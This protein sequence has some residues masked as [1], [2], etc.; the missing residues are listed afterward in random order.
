VK[1][2]AS[3]YRLQLSADFRLADA[4]AA[5]PYLD[6]LGIAALYLSP[7]T[8]ATPGSRHGYDCCD[9]TR[10][11]PELG[12]E[13]ELVLLS[14]A[15][16]ERGMGLLIDIVPNHMAASTHNPW[17]REVLAIGPAA[18]AADLFDIEWRRLGAGG[19]PQVLLPVLADR[20]GE[21]LARGDIR[22]DGDEVAYF[23]RRYP[24]AA[25][26]LDGLEAAKGD[27][28]GL[29]RLLER[30]HYRLADWRV[31]NERV[32]YRRFFDVS[33][34]VALRSQDPS[35]FERTHALALRLARAG[36][37]TGLR[38]DHV[39]GLWDPR[40]Y[41]ERLQAALGGDAWIVVEKIL[42]GDEAL[43][44]EWPVGG[45]T[46]YEFGRAVTGLQVDAGGLQ[47][48]DDLYHR[49]A[50][51]PERFA[52]LLVRQKRKML[53]ELF[54]GEMAN[55]AAEL[56]EVSD[57]QRGARDLSRHQL[58]D[59]F[60]EVTASLPVYRLY[61]RAGAARPADR[62]LLDRAVAEVTARRP[63]LDAPVLAWVRRVLALE[64]GEA[65]DDPDLARRWIDLV[66]RWQQLTGPVMAK[67][68]EDTAL[69]QYN[70]LLS[71]NMVGGEPD[72]PRRHLG[73]GEFHRR[74]AAQL[75][76]WW[77][78]LNATTTHDSKRS[79]D[80]RSRLHVLAEIPD[81]WRRA[82]WRWHAL[83]QPHRTSL[84]GR[85][86]PDP[87][88][89][90]FV[91]QTLLGAWP[92]SDGEMDGFG[93]RI[94]A[95]LVKAAREAKMHSSWLEPDEEH[96]AAL[97]D[98]A[99]AL[100]DPARAPDFHADMERLA[101]R[102]A[103]WGAVNSLAQLALKLAAPGVADFYQG[104]ELWTLTLVDP[105]NR[106]PVDLAARAEL[107]ARLERDASDP[108]D[109]VRHW[110]DGR[111]KMLVTWRGLS[112]RRAEPDLFLRGDY[113]PL[114]VSGTAAA[115]LFGFARRHLGAWLVCAVPRMPA[116]LAGGFPLGRSWRD[117]LLALPAGAPVEWTDLTTGASARAVDGSLRA[118]DLFR[119][120]P[121]ALLRADG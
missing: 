93:E 19:R 69:Y 1:V 118:A 40:G 20:Y 3:T 98:F 44:A 113:L 88:E 16:R 59:A 38:I 62:A 21:V 81:V 92:L 18:P 120:L 80:V 34:L 97:V 7:V 61:G 47:A 110:R 111:L 43:P 77:G 100:I 6:A 109:L 32:N 2:P 26:T 64:L 5:V 68:L 14:A 9:P 67:G 75:E 65:A 11:N 89:E 50:G 56:F 35:V 87:N 83:N 117:T 37:V 79:E 30:Q 46:G 57:R 105:D 58:A 86:V 85:A 31:A 33:D 70:R 90:L 104:T 116:R 42:I 119:S 36:L 66:M 73:A 13:E 76:R 107:L 106:R 24:I 27:L 108:G 39:D 53:R 96:E 51:R 4:L 22:I 15:L 95:Y 99:S 103:R 54:A 8:A 121:V 41:L 102:V 23:D 17:W 55:R 63:D 72:P 115:H 74:A 71:L 112:A 84:A 101:G 91:Y 25:D 52:D 60:A 28:D 12:S 114:E 45:T 29:H 10:V 48:L 82:V 94:S 78:G 49:F